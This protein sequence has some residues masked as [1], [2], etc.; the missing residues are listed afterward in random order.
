MASMMELRHSLITNS[1]RLITAASGNT[2]DSE[3]IASFKT[4]IPANYKEVKAYFLPFQR[5]SG[6]PSPD[7]IRPIIGYPDI[8]ITRGGRNFCVVNIKFWQQN[9]VSYNMGPNDG[10]IHLSGETTSAM[11]W[12]MNISYPE[13]SD[14]GNQ[15]DYVKWY[16]DGSYFMEHPIPGTT[17]GINYHIVNHKDYLE[18]YFTVKDLRYLATSDTNDYN[19]NWTR[20]RIQ[21]NYNC[22]GIVLYPDVFLASEPDRTHE[23]SKREN[24]T[25]TFPSTIY[26]G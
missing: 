15:R 10:T 14:T 1:T 23:K 8:T 18:N 13:F 26:G 21:R 5:G 22:E 7:N 25:I 20:I 11:S 17:N 9:G 6:D 3:V 12:H 19:F 4:D 16:P 24:Y 2:S